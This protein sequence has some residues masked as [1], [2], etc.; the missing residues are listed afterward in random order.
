MRPFDPLQLHYASFAESKLAALRDEL[1]DKGRN[2]DLATG[3]R[4]CDSSR[5]ANGVTKEVVPFTYHLASV[6]TDAD[7][8]RRARISETDR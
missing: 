5:V 1:M 7:S 3:S 2:D 8:D 6:D 4:R